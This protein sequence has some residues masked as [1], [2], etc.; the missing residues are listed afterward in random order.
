MLF[1][2]NG[3]KSPSHMSSMN[4]NPDMYLLMHS[5]TPRLGWLILL[6]YGG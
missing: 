6:T 3:Y 4:I 1:G 2:G 5:L